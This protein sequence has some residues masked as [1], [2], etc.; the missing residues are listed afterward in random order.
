MGRQGPINCQS[1]FAIP[2]DTEP[3]IYA[4]YWVWNFAKLASVDPS[5]LELYTSCMDV[6]VVEEDDDDVP[7]PPIAAPSTKRVSKGSKHSTKMEKHPTTVVGKASKMPKVTSGSYIVE[8]IYTMKF[9]TV[10][11]TV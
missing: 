2:E 11:T 10:T 5:Y 9:V 8:T 3:G 1:R 7:T 4:L 6:E